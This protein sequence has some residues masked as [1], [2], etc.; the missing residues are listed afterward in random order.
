MVIRRKMKS[1]I[2]NPHM[3]FR[4][5]MEIGCC[6]IN[7]QLARRKKKAVAYLLPLGWRRLEAPDRVF[8]VEFSILSRWMVSFNPGL[9]YPSSLALSLL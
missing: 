4:I 7:Q 1:S 9:A 8:Q 2:F 5:S 6:I 3:D